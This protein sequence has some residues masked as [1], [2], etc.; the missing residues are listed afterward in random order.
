MTTSSKGP[1]RT[2]K[3]AKA[4][5]KT[6]AMLESGVNGAEG[7]AVRER[8]IKPVNVSIVTR[9]HEDRRAAIAEAAYYRAQARGFAP[10][11]ELEDWL[12]AEEE[13]DQRLLGEGRAS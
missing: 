4:S 11:H 2:K 6:F 10:G 8:S 7:A 3:S 9:Y 5:A 13:V 12:A 1:R